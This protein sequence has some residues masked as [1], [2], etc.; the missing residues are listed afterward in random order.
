MESTVGKMIVFTC[1]CFPC[2]PV[3]LFFSSVLSFQNSHNTKFSFTY[4]YMFVGESHNGQCK[5]MVCG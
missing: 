1:S 4:R 3:V 2:L 5:I